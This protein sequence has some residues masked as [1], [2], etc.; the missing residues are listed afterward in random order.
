MVSA[1]KQKL[2]VRKVKFRLLSISK[3]RMAKIARHWVRIYR[4]YNDLIEFLYKVHVPIVTSEE[5]NPAVEIIL[6]CVMI[7]ILLVMTEALEIA[8]KG[9]RL[10]ILIKP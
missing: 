2:V 8:R 9:S 5:V 4:K 10:K 7:Y 1:G 3:N 6:K